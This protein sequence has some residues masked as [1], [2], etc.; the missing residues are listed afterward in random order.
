[1][2]DNQEFKNLKKQHNNNKIE[3]EV[4]ERQLLSLN[5]KFSENSIELEN[6]EK[7]RVVIRKVAKITQDNLKVHISN[8]VTMAIVSVNKKW[9]EFKMEIGNSYKRQ[10]IN[11]L[12]SEKG[13]EQEPLD[14]SGF[15]VVD[16]AATALNISTWALNKNRPTFIKDEPFRNLSRNNS[17]A[18]S[19]MLKM[20]CEKLKIQMII[21]SHDEEITDYADRTF[22]IKKIN[23]VS[24][25]AVGNN[26]FV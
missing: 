14:S 15:G 26:V 4:L 12:F 2:F 20:L 21:V 22:T 18:A 24:Q 23:D 10:E 16:I 13:K 6:A 17:V 25:C 3:K 7:A 1:M 19:K 8:L 5:T 9:P 11:F